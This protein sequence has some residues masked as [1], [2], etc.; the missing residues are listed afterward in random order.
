MQFIGLPPP[1]GSVDKPE[2]HV[3]ELNKSVFINSPPPR[4][5]CCSF[6]NSLCNWVRENTAYPLCLGLHTSCASSTMRAELWL[7]RDWESFVALL[8]FKP[9][10]SIFGGPV[11]GGERAML[12]ILAVPLAKHGFST[13]RNRAWLRRFGLFYLFRFG[14]SHYY[15]LE[16]PSKRN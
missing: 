5:R 4:S 8:F 10:K 15:I 7:L 3:I 1:L 2:I 14:V 12:M 13:S 9:T 6:R 16:K 11:Y